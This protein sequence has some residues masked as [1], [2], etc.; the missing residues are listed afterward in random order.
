[1]NNKGYE[2][3]AILQAWEKNKRKGQMAAGGSTI[4]Q[5]LARNLFPV[6]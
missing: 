4:T 6:D 2:V 5:Q 1:M 3:D